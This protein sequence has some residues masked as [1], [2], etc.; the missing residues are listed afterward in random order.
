MASLEDL[1]GALGKL[2]AIKT[3]LEERKEFMEFL[4]VISLLLLGCM[5]L[6]FSLCFLLKCRI[7][8]INA[9]SVR[10]WAIYLRLPRFSVNN[11]PM[12]TRK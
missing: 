6:L 11:S 7:R 8:N 2:D 1:N 3:V 10:G 9:E 4:Q 12:L 5:L